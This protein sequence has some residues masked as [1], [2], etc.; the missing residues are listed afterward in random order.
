MLIVDTDSGYLEFSISENLKSNKS[1]QPMKYNGHPMA[2]LHE[3]SEFLGYVVIDT[4]SASSEYL[5]TNV[6]WWNFFTNS[7]PLEKSPDVSSYQVP[8]WGQMKTCFNTLASKTVSVGTIPKKNISITFCPELGVDLTPAIGVIDLNYF[9]L[10][11]LYLDYP[12]NL[13]LV[14]GK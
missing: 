14:K 7:L 4:G 13:W 10:G 9:P 3:G 12:N 8:A 11:K 6:K 2:K 5:A 1:A